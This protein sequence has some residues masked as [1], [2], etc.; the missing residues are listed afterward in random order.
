[1]IFFLQ[2]ETTAAYFPD[3]ID[4]NEGVG[5]DGADQ[6][7]KLKKFTWWD[8]RQYSISW[9]TGIT[10]LNGKKGCSAI[11]ICLDSPVDLMILGTDDFQLNLT[12]AVDE[13]PIQDNGIKNKQQNAVEYLLSVWNENLQDQ[14]AEIK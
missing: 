10:A 7:L 6:L 3:F 12:F 13:Q 9:L 4:G 5:V 2:R 11:Q 8:N 1:M 14:Y